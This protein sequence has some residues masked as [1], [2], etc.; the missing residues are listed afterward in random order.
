[1]KHS[2]LVLVVRM[3]ERSIINLLSEKMTFLEF[4]GKKKL[5]NVNSACTCVVLFL[6]GGETT[7]NGL[8]CYFYLSTFLFL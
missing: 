5:G 4:L 3:V 2:M 7:L 8:C 1:M 6:N